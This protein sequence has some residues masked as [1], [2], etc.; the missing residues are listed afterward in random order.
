ME[1]RT[2]TVADWMAI[3]KRRRLTFLIPT[4]LILLIAAAVAV[5]LTPVYRSTATILIEEQEIPPNFVMSTVTTF[6]EQRLQTINQRIMSFTR[7]LEIINRF[8]LYA[9]KRKKWTTEEIFQKMRDDITFE[10]ISAEV[11]DRRTGRPMTATIAFTVSYE[12]ENPETVHQVANVLASLYLEENIQARERQAEETSTFLKDEMGS[13]RSRLAELDAQIAR[14]KEQHINELPEL[15][16]VNLQGLDRH[17]RDVQQLN[18]Q[19]RSLR[20]REGSL[21]TQLASLPPLSAD[22]QRLDEL[23]VQMVYLK[24]RYS[25]QY[26]EVIRTKAEIIELEKRLGLSDQGDYK[27]DASAGTFKPDN[28]AYV[29]IAS[30]LSSIQAEIA[31]VKQQIEA[32]QARLKEYQRR[33]EA[34][35]RVE[36][37]YRVLAFER[38]NTQL[39]LN[40]LMTKSMEA[41]VAHGLEKEQKAERFTLIDPPRFPEEPHKPNRLAIMLIG[42]VLAIG[43]GIG[44]ASIR[45]FTDQSIR[46]ERDLVFHTSFPVL[47]SIPFIETD[48]EKAR[49]KR[50]QLHIVVGIAIIIIIGLLI[51][52]FFVMDF[53]ILW[54]KL[55][56]RMP[57]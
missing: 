21:Q 15:L 17:E 56:R 26:P 14:F 54:V 52:H 19:I 5:A 11:V 25:D 36:E 12:G 46:S 6:V 4:V 42:L 50:R 16:P 24:E 39:K 44:F 49:K 37:E 9:D 43:A 2:T 28:P 33:I 41:K 55:A 1:E 32:A 35:P 48:Q 53:Q 31:L 22:K 18:D 10:P 29:T 40:D 45:E 8:N 30:Q 38:D 34:S 13:I 57:W 47:G 51:F 27:N 23:R 20:E 3:M 7:L